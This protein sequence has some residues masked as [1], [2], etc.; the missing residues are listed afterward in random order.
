MVVKRITTRSEGSK[1]I[2]LILLISS[3]FNPIPKIKI[4][5]VAVNCASKIWLNKSWNCPAKT[6]MPPWKINIGITQKR[7][8]IPYVEAR[9]MEVKPSS[10]DLVNSRDISPDIPSF[11]APTIVIEPMQKIRNAVT[12]PSVKPLSLNFNFFFNASL[13]FSI[14]LSRWMTSP[15]TPPMRILKINIKGSLTC[16]A[17]C[18]PISS[19]HNPNPWKTMVLMLSGN[20][21][22]NSNPIVPPIKTAT[23]L[24]K[25]PI[26][27]LNNPS[28]GYFI[29]FLLKRIRNG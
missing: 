13:I 22:R 28:S 19:V 1:L 5:P 25:V 15:K 14:F 6:V 26:G 4:P 29:A 2:T 27:I 10:I 20:L 23:M 21:L 12:S 8:P 18:I 3:K 17:I 24:I 11:N 9:A 16:K 7:T